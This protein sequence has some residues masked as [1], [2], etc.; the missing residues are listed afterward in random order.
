LPVLGIVD[1][2]LT[3]PLLGMLLSIALHLVGLLA[4]W[5]SPP[6]PVRWPAN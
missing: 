4:S 3:H 1:A 2:S 5:G 6:S